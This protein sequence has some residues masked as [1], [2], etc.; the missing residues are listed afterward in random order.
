[1]SD[2]DVIVVGAG[3]AGNTAAYLLA[4]AGL[5]VLVIERGETI[6]SKNVTGGRMYS[7][8][9]EKI[10][11]DFAKEAPVGRR[12]TK[13]RIS[14]LTAD[15]AT[16]V[17]Y[18]AEKLGEQGKA[19]YS[20]L[21][22]EFD[23]WL[24]GKAEEAGAEYVTGVRVDEI[25]VQDG[26]VTGVIAGG[27]EMTADVVLLADGVNSLLAQQ[28]GMKKE[29]EPS[30]VAVGVKEVIKLGEQKINERFGVSNGDG[31][32][33]LFA[34]DTT[35]GSIGG[36][37]LYTNKDSLS[38]GIVTTIAEIGRND[39]APRDMVERLKEHPVVKPLIKDGEMI[40][41][42]AHLVTEG[43]YDMIPT[44]YRD[45]VLV[46]GDAA[47]FVMNL[48]FTIRGMDLCIESGRLAAETIIKAKEAG[49]FSA[50]TL[51]QYK[52]ALDNSFIMKDML[53]F[54]K[55]PKFIENHRIFT[56]Y[57]ALADKIMSDLFIMY[58][59]EPVKFKKKAMAAVKDVGIMNL[60]K[61]G[62]SAMGAM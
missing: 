30:Q 12:I 26:K 59:Q 5:G 14:M 2:F 49:D 4:K 46:A 35:G 17:E 36:G 44:L 55:M 22:A 1:M 7:H 32:A 38:L 42:A 11:P 13:E 61:D 29:L 41:Y 45:N 16:T 24:A 15:S 51:S 25:L 60:L 8:S 33:W 39:I 43:G 21:R 28:L 10:F 53:H 6:G 31:V 54:R 50:K 47:A 20:I 40:E 3:L 37:F 9:L 57:P 19:T 27:D 62:M 48:G 52:T 34:G 56:Q 23:P 18:A 58:G